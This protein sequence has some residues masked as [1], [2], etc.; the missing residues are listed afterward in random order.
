MS[1]A[2]ERFLGASRS[3]ADVNRLPAV[4]VQRQERFDADGVEQVVLG[5]MLAQVAVIPMQTDVVTLVGYGG[6]KAMLERLS[7]SVRGGRLTVSGEVPLLPGRSSGTYFFGDSVTV[8]VTGSG[9]FTSFSSGSGSKRLIVDSREVDL[10]RAIQ[11]GIVVPVSMG[12]KVAGMAGAI[13]VA[14]D[15]AGVLDFSP[16]LTVDL[17]AHRVGSLAG[18]VSGASHAVI[19]RVDGEAA[20]EISGSG[21]VALGGVD[22]AA[23]LHVSGS[24][25]ISIAGGR[26]DRLRARV[27][28][29]GRIRHD[30]VVTGDARLRVSGSGSVSA[31]RVE[32]DV[33]RSVS[34]SGTVR[35]NGERHTSRW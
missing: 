19:E 30:G 24:G 8:N 14:G 32:G 17:Y 33:D 25:L 31:A 3:L 16:S 34:G 9:S 12:V 4:G 11:I 22:G 7:V 10:D 2:V 35:A 18:D 1:G 21:A 27:S 6:D 23:D 28:G 29:S 15:L 20:V 26:T 5:R 13:G